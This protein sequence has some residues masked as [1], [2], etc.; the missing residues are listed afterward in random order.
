MAFSPILYGC[1]LLVK[2]VLLEVAQL[3]DVLS[4][5]I[6]LLLYFPDFLNY[7]ACLLVVEVVLSLASLATFR[8]LCL[9]FLDGR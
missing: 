5:A 7:H 6:V 9:P 1:R 2:L 8:S 4:K 3:L